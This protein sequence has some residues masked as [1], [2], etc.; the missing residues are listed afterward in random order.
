MALVSLLTILPYATMDTFTD[1]PPLTPI[2]SMLAD[3]DPNE[4]EDPIFSDDD[5]TILSSAPNTLLTPSFGSGSRSTDMDSS[6][7]D[8]Q[9]TTGSTI[10]KRK[11]IQRTSYVFNT[12]NGVEYTSREGRP[13]W[14]CV[15]CSKPCLLAKYCNANVF[16][17]PFGRTAQTFAVSGTKNMIDHLREAH[18]IDKDGVMDTE[19]AVNQRIDKVFGKATKRIEF[20]LDM[21]KQL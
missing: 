21:F 8:T 4:F 17:G 5:S 3:I 2:S 6:A 7:S 10:F 14:R 11:K 13:R 16:A 9:A 18:R 1:A 20:N 15:H 12:A 19:G